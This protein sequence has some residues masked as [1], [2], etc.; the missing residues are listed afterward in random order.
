MNARDLP[1]KAAYVAGWRAVKAL[2]DG[3]PGA[4]VRSP[5]CWYGEPAPAALASFR[6]ALQLRINERGGLPTRW[7]EARETC[8]RRDQS[9]ITDYRLR[10]IVLSGSGL[11]SRA[12]RR[13]APDVHAAFRARMDEL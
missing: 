11:Q 2:A 9:A 8:E 4:L 5:W 10:R 1:A 13:A 3:D 12:G 6:R 7:D